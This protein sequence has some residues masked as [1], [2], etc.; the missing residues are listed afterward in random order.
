M[1]PRLSE[2]GGV[3]FSLSRTRSLVCVFVSKAGPVGVDAESLQALPDLEQLAAV[4]L[5][6]NESDHLRSRLD[7]E[8]FLAVWTRKEALAKALG[9]GL[10]D[11]ARS[12]EVPIP[13]AT[14]RDRPW[15]RIDRQWI[16]ATIR[17]PEGGGQIVS[18]VASLA[19]HTSVGSI[20]ILPQATALKSA[21]RAR[22]RFIAP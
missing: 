7:A 6:E 5:S 8:A 12:L 17:P 13:L 2:G 16:V 14:V 21:S 10:P 3:Y 20:K 11:D 4:V 22:I 15:Q 19:G 18:I 9:T 1:A